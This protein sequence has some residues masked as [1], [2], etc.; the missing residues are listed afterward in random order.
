MGLGALRDTNSRAPAACLDLP[1]HEATSSSTTSS[2]GGG[3]HHQQPP[4]LWSLLTR[5]ERAFPNT[6]LRSQEDDVS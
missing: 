6:H 5:L 4:E 3:K 2:N 1:H